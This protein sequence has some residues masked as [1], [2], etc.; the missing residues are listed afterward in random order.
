MMEFSYFVRLSAMDGAAKGTK[1]KNLAFSCAALAFTVLIVPAAVQPFA[2]RAASRPGSSPSVSILLPINVPSQ[3]VQIAYQLIGPFGGYLT[4]MEPKAGLNSLE[5]EASLEGRAAT[6]IRMII[7]AS[8]CEF[9]TVV[10]PLAA[11][12]KTTHEFYCEAAR[13]VRL[14]GRIVTSDLTSIKDT[15]L[16]INYRAFWAH[17][18]FGIAD[19]MVTEFRVATVDPE[20][21][22]T[23]RVELP[24]F[25]EDSAL[26]SEDPESASTLKADL[27]LR[28]DD[29]ET[30]NRIAG[31][32]P[33]I[34]E[35]RS[36]LDGLRIRATYP[37][38]LEITPAQ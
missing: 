23:F 24:Y 18:F 29:P 17:H 32:I 22:G 1:I 6:E 5:I 14:S 11:D 2:G 27:S 19:G 35:F 21:D 9:Q 10:L 15:E 31:L 33:V 26:S 28:L 16:F 38:E 36:A 4:Y 25:K 34:R 20:K 37:G 8:G 13:S 3:T 7:Y 30:G 12:S